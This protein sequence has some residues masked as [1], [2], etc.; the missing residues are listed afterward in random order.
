MKYIEIFLKLAF[1]IISV[2]FIITNSIDS[3]W[4]FVSL[5]VSFLLGIILI[6]NKN[7]SYNYPQTDRDYL[8][9]RI[10]GVLLLIF[11]L[12]AFFLIY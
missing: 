2:M 3:S 12:T 11:S 7:S 6:I 8:I 4:F 5:L 1:L 9:S 10:E